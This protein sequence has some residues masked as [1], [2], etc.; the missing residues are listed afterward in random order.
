MDKVNI[1]LIGLLSFTIYKLHE[2]NKDLLMFIN[3]MH[4]DVEDVDNIK[5]IYDEI[6]MLKSLHKKTNDSLKQIVKKLP[7]KGEEWMQEYIREEINEN[8]N[9]DFDAINQ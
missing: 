7:F 1:L 3:R 8:Y 5:N 2:Q 9:M 6:T 4:P